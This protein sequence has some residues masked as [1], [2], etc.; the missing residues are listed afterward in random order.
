MNDWRSAWVAALDDLE[1][2]IAQVEELLRT[3]Q[4][5]RDTPPADPWTP[6]EGMGPLPLDLRPRADR[7][8]ARQIAAA[9]GIARAMAVNRRQA[10][11]TSRIELFDS[12]AAPPA[13]LDRAM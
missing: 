7:I 1:A 13:Y 8:L 10:A 2:D 3:D 11:M 12:G 6:P 9:E 5:V 4:F